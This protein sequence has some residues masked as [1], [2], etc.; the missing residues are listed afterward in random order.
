VRL[1]E[2]QV[3]AEQEMKR[4]ELEF[5]RQLEAKGR[6]ADARLRQELQQKE[7]AFQVKLKQREQELAMKADARETECRING[8][9]MCAAAR[10]NGIARPSR[11]SMPS[12]PASTR[13][14]SRKDELFASKSRQRE[15]QWQS[16]LD[17]VRA[18]LQVQTEEILRRRDAEAD[19]RVREV[20]AQ[21]RKETQQKE[22]ATQA[23]F[24]QRE[25]DLVTQLTAQ[26]EA[27]QMAAR[28]QWETEAEKKARAAIEPFKGLLARAESERDEAK[29][30]AFEKSRQVETWKRNSPKRPHSLMAGETVRV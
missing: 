15:Q 17:A 5:E 3:Q 8:L 11:V 26:A 13:K 4:R 9:P 10:R 21:L 23:N 27:R 30:T 16:K 18:E 2:L 24:A 25:Q 29:Q 12:K 6:E 14:R 1:N 22:E 19:A 7:L 28:A 20:E